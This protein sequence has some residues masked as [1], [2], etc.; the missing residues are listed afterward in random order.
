[1]L[2]FL[3][4]WLR[5]LLRWLEELFGR[6]HPPEPPP[7]DCPISWT[8]S[9]LAPVFYGVRDYTDAHD[10]PGPCRV[11]FPSLDGA[12]FDAP[13]LE[14]C[15]RYP[16][17]LFAHG[18]CD[19][20]EHYKKWYE[21]PAQLARSGYVVVV[22]EMPSIAVHPSNEDHA[23]LPRMSAIV[24]W[25]RAG[26]EHAGVLMPPPATGVVGHSFGAL[27]GAR[28][29]A[30]NPVSAYASIAGVWE[31]WPGGPLP[32]TD[33]GIPMLLALGTDDWF[34][35]ISNTL[36]N[37]LSTPKH[38]AVYDLAR[39]WDYLRPGTTSC[40]NGR[41]PCTL[42]GMLNAD[43]V[44]MFFARYLPPEGLGGLPGQI[45]LSLIPPPLVLTTEQQFFAGGHLMGFTLL[46]S[47]EGCRVTL[48][49]DTA[50]GSGT[51]TRP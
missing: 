17:I 41:G 21:L 39:H 16:L 43:I 51:T 35:N 49:W 37:S 50:S 40:E 26:W 2:S 36:W 4:R 38:K 24:E 15:G 7:P 47:R 34:T 5:R 8:P 48:T 33:V 10:A 23:S 22:P 27:L 11:F 13:I 6:L 29:A 28:F 42:T 46:A 9:A 1:M 18:H 12:V 25:M 3:I 45:P 30:G 31:D 32:I 44:T 14:G 20:A 19:E